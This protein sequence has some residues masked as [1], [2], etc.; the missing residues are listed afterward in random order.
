[1]KTKRWDAVVGGDRDKEVETKQIAYSKSLRHSF[2]QQV[3][4]ECLP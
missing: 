2:C 4:S 3:F 1:M